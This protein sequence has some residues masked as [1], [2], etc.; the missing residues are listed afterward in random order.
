MSAK[1]SLTKASLTR[2]R[3]GLW[4]PLIARVFPGARVILALRHPC[5]ACLSCT[6]QN[7][8]TNAAMASFHTLD[9]A[10][11]T[12]AA[13]M[14]LLDTWV[15]DFP[16]AVHRIRYE[17]LVADLEAEARRL[18]AYLGVGWNPAVLEPARRARAR[19]IINTPSYHQVVRPIYRSALARWERY[20]EAFAPLLPRLAP[21]I[22]GYGYAPASGAQSAD[23]Q[24]LRSST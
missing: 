7:F 9:H 13:V 11:Q 16:R 8:A 3:N 23:H 17:D 24:P 4:L 18:L 19:R 2:G 15:A 14:G 20:G 10:A 1:A 12:Y 22:R 21:F 5:D 6:M